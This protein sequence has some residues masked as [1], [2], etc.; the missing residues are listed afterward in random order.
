MLFRSGSTLKPLSRRSPV[1]KDLFTQDGAVDE[2]P[3]LG[4]SELVK[5]LLMQ[6][7]FVSS[8]G[9]TWKSGAV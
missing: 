1:F 6:K 4:D 9:A 7:T 2:L 3:D 5:E 8:Y